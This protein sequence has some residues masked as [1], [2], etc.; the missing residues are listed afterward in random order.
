MPSRLIVVADHR[1]AQMFRAEGRKIHEAVGQ[2]E[3]KEAGSL[4]P[5]SRREGLSQHMGVAGHFFFPHTEVKEVEKE[6]FAR[7]LSHEIYKKM[8]NG[9]FEEL[10]LVAEPKMLG[11]LRKNL[12]HSFSHI[13]IHKALNLDVT[14]LNMKELEAKVFP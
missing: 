14:T 10:I 13:L 4:Q 11:L 5:R 9:S 12:K 1:K 6:S 8:E 2:L 7:L 3:N